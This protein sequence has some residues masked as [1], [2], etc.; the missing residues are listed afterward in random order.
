MKKSLLVTALLILT[1]SCKKETETTAVEVAADTI[2]TPQNK[3]LA[4][5]LDSVAMIKAWENYMMPGEPHKMLAT[6]DGNWDTDFILYHSADDKNPMKIKMTATSKMILGGRFQESRH[7][8]VM[9][10][11]PFE[12][13]SIM[14]YDN[15]S[16]KMVATWY[17][18]M[19]TGI[20][21]LTGEFDAAKKMLS[22]RG[23][24]SDVMTGK[25]KPYRETYTFVDENTRKMVMYD[26]DQNGVEYK[27]IDI[28]MK[29]KP[30]N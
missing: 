6:D 10:G 4:A 30:M 9:Y 27:S 3:A 22:L 14:G 13:V 16:K 29:R 21:Y 1:A 8:G 12:G 23:E 15:A 25:A 19:G 28:T 26:V 11:K 7:I 5:P 24:A 20:M 18:N 17:D 2:S